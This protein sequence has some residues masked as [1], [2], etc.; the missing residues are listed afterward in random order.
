MAFWQINPTSR[1]VFQSAT[2][3]VAQTG[4]WFDVYLHGV[5]Y[6]GTADLA[7][8]AAIFGAFNP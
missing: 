2:V 4:G 1:I 5:H 8:A 6:T 7:K 3:T